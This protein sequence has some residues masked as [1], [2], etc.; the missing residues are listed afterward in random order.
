MKGESLQSQESRDEMRGEDLSKQGRKREKKKKR[1]AAPPERNLKRTRPP[2]KFDGIRSVILLQ[3]YNTTTVL[4]T[5][6]FS[7]PMQ[8]SLGH[9]YPNLE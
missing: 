5:S 6:Q 7:G 4:R 3:Y 2:R 8:R 9:L 1:S